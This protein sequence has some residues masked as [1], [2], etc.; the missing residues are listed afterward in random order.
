MDFAKFLRNPFFIEKLSTTASVFCSGNECWCKRCGP[1]DANRNCLI[2]GEN[3]N[4]FTIYLIN[5][6]K[7]LTILSTLIL[8]VVIKLAVYCST[9]WPLLFSN[10]LDT[11]LSQSCNWLIKLLKMFFI[12]ITFFTFLNRESSYFSYKKPSH[13]GLFQ[14]E[15]GGGESFGFFRVWWSWWI[16][17][18][19]WQVVVGGGWCWH[20]LF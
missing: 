7:E 6:M 12:I 4:L 17:F 11:L 5:T 15:V 9:R 18:G 13:L 8:H 1:I 10:I 14:L 19:W 20:S 2:N 16:F 3:L